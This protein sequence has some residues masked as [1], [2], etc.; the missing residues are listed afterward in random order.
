M[1]RQS[2]PDGVYQDGRTRAVTTEAVLGVVER[3]GLPV[4][5]VAAGAAILWQLGGRLLTAL[6]CA[7]R[8][9]IDALERDRD[10]FRDRSEAHDDRTNGLCRELIDECRRQPGKGIEP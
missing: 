5:L 1:L 6:V 3:V 9:R 7:Y 8:A 10:H 4:V 2:R